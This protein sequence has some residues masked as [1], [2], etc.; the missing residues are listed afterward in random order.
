M[1]SHEYSNSRSGIHFTMQHIFQYVQK[2]I[3]CQIVK[4]HLILLRMSIV[5]ERISIH[6]LNQTKTW[7]D[8]TWSADV[9][10]MTHDNNT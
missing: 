2:K 7:C 8:V 10:M 1:D 9:T 6:V 5:N 3:H 4:T